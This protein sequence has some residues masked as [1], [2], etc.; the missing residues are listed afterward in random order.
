MSPPS[1]DQLGTA[2]RRRVL[3]A[4]GACVL[5]LLLQLPVTSAI[6][7]AGI[8]AIV[9]SLASRGAVAGWLRGL[10]AI[11][12]RASPCRQSRRW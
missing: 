9:A 8:G 11:A 12:R 6:A 10:L 1:P 2:G 4:A 7:I 5:P 3:L